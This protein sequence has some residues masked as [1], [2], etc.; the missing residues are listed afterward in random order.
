MAQLGY[1]GGSMKK[2]FLILL[3]FAFPL[4]SQ[5]LT[6]YNFVD[7]HNSTSTALDSAE[8]FTGTATQLVRVVGA[9]VVNNA[10]VAAICVNILAS[11][12]SGT[13]TAQFSYDG[14]HWEI[15]HS[16]AYT[17]TGNITSHW[18][19]P[20]A[21]FFRVVYTNGLDDLTRLSIQTI[22][23]KQPI[24]H[25]VEEYT[26]G[27]ETLIDSVQVNVEESNVL[28]QRN[29]VM[30]DSVQ[31]NVE[32]GNVLSQH[33][34]T[35]LLAQGLTLDSTKTEL[36]A[37]GISLDSLD[38]Q[39]D[40]QITS[41]VQ[42]RAYTDGLEAFADSVDDQTDR[43][44]T[45]LVA[46]RG[47]TDQLEGYVDGLETPTD[48]INA[49]TDRIITSLVAIRG[50][51]DGLELPS[52]S[53]NAQT[54]RIIT[55]L[56]AIRGYVDGLEAPTDSINNQSDRQITSLVELRA[57][58][59]TTNAR[60]S[61]YLAAIENNTDA[62]EGSF[63]TTLGYGNLTV[64]TVDTLSGTSVETKTVTITNNSVGTTLYVG[65]DGSTASTNGFPLLY[66]DSI[67]LNI[68]NLN[69]IYL[70]SSGSSDVRYIW[71]K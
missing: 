57:K 71:S 12:S 61:Q 44:I 35:E 54:D 56:V 33:I 4:F 51:T 31:V 18:Y 29:I 41:L 63:H 62:L 9:T 70:V 26:D 49:Q 39:S 68:S 21:P 15:T 23:Y 25:N 45:S 59:D 37:Q 69:K 66:L 2:I 67:T 46:L 47:Y 19:I 30:T 50:Y 64:S 7:W 28:I 14:T 20:E 40:R 42:L 60:L 52:D 38:N 17:D 43:M 3:G 10:E 24:L 65:S 22:L 11:D 13:A 34:R 27:L 16:I 48:S 8:T 53:I 55:S 1:N 58:A 36:L 32:E 6:P 5:T